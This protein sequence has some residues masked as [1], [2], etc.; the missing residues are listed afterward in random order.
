MVPVIL[1]TTLLP[2]DLDDTSTTA[3]VHIVIQFLVCV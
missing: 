2:G 1:A 3:C